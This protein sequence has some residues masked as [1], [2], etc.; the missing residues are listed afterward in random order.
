MADLPS[1]MKAVVNKRQGNNLVYGLAEVPTPTVSGDRD[2]IVKVEASPINPSDL[3][4]LGMVARFGGDKV[5]V[6][7]SPST[8]AAPLPAAAA[9]MFKEDGETKPLGSEGSGVVVAAG[10]SAEAQAL[11]GKRVAMCSGGCYAQYAKTV[12]DSPMFA[13][14]PD[15]VTGAE[16]AS[17]FVNPLTVVGFVHTMKEEGHKAIVHTAA[18]SQLGRMLVKHCQEE[19]VPLVNIARKEEGVAALKAIGAEFVVNSTAPTFK[20][21][22]LAAVKTTGATIAF[23]ATGGGT[24]AMD[25]LTAFDQ[26]LRELYPETVQGWYGP[27]QKRSVYKYGGLDTSNSEFVPSLGVGNWTWE[28]WLMP[29]HYAKYAPEH[30]AA[31]ISKVVAGLK[32][33]FSTAFGTK[34][35]LEDMAKSPEEYFATLQSQTDK[36]FLVLPN[37]E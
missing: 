4:S 8:V 11:I 5:N 9:G 2:L 10:A 24:L 18:A 31:G 17:M 22:L 26:S 32:T 33:T 35:S 15:G 28:G 27:P 3:A 20:E 37:G 1:T 19:G 21:D 12:V 36:K 34:L 6:G 30:R 29:F 7:E 16:G 23:D 13:V 14:L 25:I